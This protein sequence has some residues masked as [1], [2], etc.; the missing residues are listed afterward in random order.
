MNMTLNSPYCYQVLQIS[1]SGLVQIQK[2]KKDTKDLSMVLKP[3]WHTNF[4]ML[5]QK[6]KA[7]HLFAKMYFFGLKKPLKFDVKG[8]W[9][10]KNT[11]LQKLQKLGCGHYVVRSCTLGCFHSYP[12]LKFN[13]KIIAMQNFVLCGTIGISY[14]WVKE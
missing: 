8:M 9:Y 13:L 10:Q 12:R 1:H 7:K 2:K 6:I 11:F 4:K 3:F 5:K 14:F